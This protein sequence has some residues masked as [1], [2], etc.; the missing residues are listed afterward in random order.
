MSVTRA[1]NSSSKF[2]QRFL[3]A[4][5]AWAE[6]GTE[7]K[8]TEFSKE[9]TLLHYHDAN[10]Q[11]SRVGLTNDQIEVLNR[12]STLREKFLKAQYEQF[13]IT[14][15]TPFRL[16]VEEEFY[17]CDEMGDPIIS[18]GEPVPGHPDR[19]L[20]FKELQL[21]IIF[22]SKFGRKEVTPAWLNLQ[23]RSYAVMFFDR[24]AVNT[25]VVAITQPWAKHPNDFHSA[26]YSA[27]QIPEFRA[28]LIKICRDTEPEDAPRNASIEACDHCSVVGECPMSV[29]SMAETAVTNVQKMTPAEL[30]SI[31]D[32]VAL[33]K[34]V[35]AQWEERMK[36]IAKT[37]P[38]LLKTYE[39]SNTNGPREITDTA[40]S[41][42]CLL[43]A[44]LIQRQMDPSKFSDIQ[45]LIEVIQQN[46]AEFVWAMELFMQCCKLSIGGLEEAVAKAQ[47][48]T[49]R[50][51]SAN[52]AAALGPLIQVQPR[53]PSLVKKPKSIHEGKT[54][55]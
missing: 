4:G 26:E 17:L 47:G 37:M 45:P 5:S 3:C 16:I 20:Y 27:N 39:L 14:P 13:G 40:Y 44:R 35:I 9:G 22:D 46:P 41:F 25:I 36:M 51:A 15:T 33:A 19:I 8:E 29:S 50:A 1:I 10:P 21:A 28:E 43:Q 11:V 24:F 42:Q 53:E 31:G 18:H 2:Q 55:A 52:I 54:L 38:L 23:L 6:K 49:Q 34:R 7:S 30:E 48:I 32:D 12:N